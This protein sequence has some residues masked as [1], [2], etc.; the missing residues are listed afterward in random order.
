METQINQAKIITFA[1]LNRAVQNTY[2]IFALKSTAQKAV[3][4]EVSPS[5]PE[6]QDIGDI[7]FIETER[8]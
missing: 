1:N 2:K 8:K 4:A 5:Q 6:N 7:W 3:N